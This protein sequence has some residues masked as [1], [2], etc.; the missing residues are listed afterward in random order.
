M[1]VEGQRRPSHGSIL[2]VRYVVEIGGVP[3]LDRADESEQV[4]RDLGYEAAVLCDHE[5]LLVAAA[6]LPPARV[7]A[8]GSRT[9]HAG[10]RPLMPHR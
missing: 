3:C 9:R 5:R 8:D 10:R 4:L 7:G 6:Y 1:V 2:G